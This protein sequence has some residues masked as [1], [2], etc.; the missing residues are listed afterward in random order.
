LNA[1]WTVLQGA[2]GLGQATAETMDQAEAGQESGI[3]QE[4][5]EDLSCR[6][7]PGRSHKGKG[8][9]EFGGSFAGFV[10]L[11]ATLVQT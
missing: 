4:E 1:A 11:V 5:A 9:T 2:L 10:K 8:A 7:R 3:K 6:G